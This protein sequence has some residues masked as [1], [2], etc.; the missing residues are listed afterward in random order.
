L[1]L[2]GGCRGASLE[3]SG[4]GGDPTDV[5]MPGQGGQGGGTRPGTGG[6]DAGGGGGADGAGGAGPVASDVKISE[7]MYH[8]VLEEAA[9]EAHEFVELHNAGKAAVTL[10][11]WRLDGDVKL[12]FPRGTTLP[13]GGYL[14]AAKDKKALVGVQ[15]YALDEAL[16]VGDY[17]G[18]LDNGKGNVSLVD[19]AG[20]VVESVVYKDSFPWPHAADALGVGADWLPKEKLPLDKHR[21]LGHS[22]E[23]A[24]FDVAATEVANWV[25]SALDGA[26][27][28]K[29]NGAPGGLA[30]VVLGV[31]ATPQGATGLIRKDHQ[32]V[33]KVA[34]SKVGTVNAPAI[35]A[36]VDDLSKEGEPATVTPLAK[37]GDGWEATL[38]AQPDG[39]IVR[40]R[41][42]DDRDGRREAVSPRPSDPYSHHAYF[43]SPPI[44]VKGRFYQIYIAPAAWTRMWTN[45]NDSLVKGC[46]PNPLW[47]KHEPAV[48][49]VDGEVY[50]VRTRYS[51]SRFHRRMGAGGGPDNHLKKERPFASWTVPGPDAPK[52]LMA[53]S[54]HVKLPRYKELDGRETIKLNK[55]LQSCPG[56]TAT[57]TG[58]IYNMLGIPAS[59]PRFARVFVNGA[60]YHYMLEHEG[61]V[62]MIERFYKGGPIGELYKVEGT[63][64]ELGPYYRGDAR[65]LEPNRSC[66]KW[67]LEDRY[68]HVYS[69]KNFEWKGPQE[70][71]QLI[72]D[73]HAARAAGTEAIRRFFADKF[74]LDKL[75]TYV[76]IRNWAGG[77]DDVHQNHFYYK[78]PDGK[79]I[80]LPWDVDLE[81]GGWRQANW[82]FYNGEEGSP[83][84]LESGWWNRLK[85]ALMK[86]YR[87]E[88]HAKLRELDQ[89]VLAPESFAKILDQ[90]MADA[91][92][93]REAFLAAPVGPFMCNIDGEIIRSK[94]FAVDRR[95]ELNKL[96][97]PKPA[98]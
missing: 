96:L 74:D 49:V 10:D 63:N 88:Y 97:A 85:D 98:P 11:G 94:K 75:M 77:G 68:R 73:L 27:P 76:A 93:D 53:L 50:D 81:Y 69:R 83:T 43:V 12:T 90:S 62:D 41:V 55:L 80:L 36:F 2:F 1:L 30:A 37:V 26:T 23:R 65:L 38:P 61:N 46:D 54:W 84:P 86:A 24:R 78:R 57:V 4:P 16:V 19:A 35:E 58:H 25:P 9:T 47:D 95:V 14:V 45:T 5:A 39:S 91:G 44:D 72:K 71:M 70:I 33:V 8:P 18:E 82:H 66:P 15:A 51:G 40:Y 34:F 67:T 13:P 87:A 48:L 17:E 6:R 31:T 59:I 56:F 42:V 20:K 52:P 21:H 60:Y 92:F 79:W 7:I 3:P 29:A 32:V 89:G 22:L 28:G 64:D